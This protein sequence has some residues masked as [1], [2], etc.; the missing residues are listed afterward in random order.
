M[1]NSQCRVEIL[2]GHKSDRRKVTLLIYPGVGYVDA[3]AGHDSLSVDDKRGLYS[4]F[5]GWI[6]GKINDRHY[7]GWSK[8][9]H[10]GKYAN[11]FVFKLSDLRFYGFLCHPSDKNKRLLVCVL[12]LHALKHQWSTETVYLDRVVKM[13]ENSIVIKAIKEIFPD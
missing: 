6:A 10:R 2:A 9:Q 5:D 8:G 12:V 3:K 1:S 11:C 4:R 13:S 7:H